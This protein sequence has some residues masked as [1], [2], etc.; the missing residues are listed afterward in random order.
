[1][2]H[3]VRRARVAWAKQREEAAKHAPGKRR[4]E[5]ARTAAG[6]AR[7][8][9][10]RVNRMAAEALPKRAGG[11]KRAERPEPKK[12]RTRRMGTWRV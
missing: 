6:K 3:P 4:S 10:E 7:V 9:R 8:R 2:G 12:A 1:M 11:H 5:N